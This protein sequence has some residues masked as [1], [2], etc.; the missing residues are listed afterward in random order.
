M[1]IVILILILILIVFIPKKTKMN[2]IENKIVIEKKEEKSSSIEEKVSIY[3]VDIKGEIVNPGVYPFN[4]NERIIDL[5][6]K[7][8]GLTSNASTKNINLSKKLTDEMVV[9]I[10]NKEEINIETPIEFEQTNIIQNEVSSNLNKEVS[11]KLVSLNTASKEELMTLSGI[12]ESKANSIIEYRNKKKFNSIEDIKLV[13]GIGE[14]L[15]EK[16]KNSITI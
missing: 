15:F 9:V 16:I 6:N 1:L 2:S 11:N 4:D 10:Y 7:A 14:S 8:G 13:S 12:G 3:K 5:I